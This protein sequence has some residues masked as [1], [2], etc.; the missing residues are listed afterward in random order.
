MNTVGFVFLGYLLM[1]SLGIQQAL[2]RD[3][4]LLRKVIIVAAIGG[5]ISLFLEVSQY[6]IIPGRHSNLIDLI[7][8]VFGTF[9]GSA[10]CIVLELTRASR[11]GMRGIRKRCEDEQV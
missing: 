1:L 7:A 3:D 2:S 9:V 5:V 4:S 6:Y 10:I 8:N 11:V